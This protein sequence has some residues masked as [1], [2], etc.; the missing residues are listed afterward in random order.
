MDSRCIADEGVS[1]VPVAL[2]LSKAGTL[3]A[4]WNYENDGV[5][6]DEAED[7]A[8]TGVYIL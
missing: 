6:E 5:D 4:G 3:Y 1:L 8:E 2:C 7:R